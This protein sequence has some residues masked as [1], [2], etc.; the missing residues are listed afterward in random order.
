MLF[1]FANKNEPNWSKGNNR[2]RLF[3]CRARVYASKYLGLLGN[4]DCF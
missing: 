1:F 2:K 3:T 4:C